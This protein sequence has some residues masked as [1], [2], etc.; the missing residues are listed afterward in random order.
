MTLASV[1]SIHL[2][3]FDSLRANGG[4][5]G[6]PG[7]GVLFC[8]VASDTRA[9]GTD[10][11][12]QQAFK[13]LMLALHADRDS[14]DRVLDQRRSLL[15][16]MGQAHEV[17]AAVL[18][19][20]RHKGEANYLSRTGPATPLFETVTP[21]IPPDSPFVA[22]TSSGW[23]L[24]DDLDRS[25]IQ[26]FSAGVA[27]IRISMTAVPGLHSQQSFFFPGGL[28]LDPITVSF[29]RNEASAREF[30]FGPGVHRLQMDRD[31]AQ[32]LADRLSF[33]R[34]SVLRSC[35]TWHGVDPQL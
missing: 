2:A 10:P 7:P 28:E 21:P 30:S 1:V 32:K 31:R 3:R 34:C 16:W 18:Q 29:W 20:F 8:A 33:T 23:N 25:R 22:I 14:A 24:T 27:A 11:T 26:K 4:I 35:G 6:D 19:P 15:P 12:S 17:Y 9:A 13:F 5:C